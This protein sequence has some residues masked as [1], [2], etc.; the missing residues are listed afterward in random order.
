MTIRREL[1]EGEI[2]I[3]TAVTRLDFLSRR[4]SAAALQCPA[5][6]ASHSWTDHLRG[7]VEALDLDESLELLD[8]GVLVARQAS[9]AQHRG[10]APR[11]APE[12]VGA[13]RWGAQHH[14]ADGVAQPQRWIEEQVELFELTGRD[15]LD[16]VG[17]VVALKLAGER[18]VGLRYAAHSSGPDSGSDPDQPRP[19]LAAGRV[20]ERRG[21]PP[22]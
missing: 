16:D 6:R 3:V 2:P 22:S 19:S 5:V 21:R 13:H 11:C 18:P 9:D 20:D 7:Q 17:A 1:R 10:T 12:R 4:D 8:L 15:G 14:A